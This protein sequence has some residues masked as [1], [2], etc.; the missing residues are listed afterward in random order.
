MRGSH[1]GQ[2]LPEVSKANAIES[3]RVISSNIVA[4]V[5]LVAKPYAG[6]ALYFC[7]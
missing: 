5:C 3:D 4:G 2:W 7:G 1:A 6:I